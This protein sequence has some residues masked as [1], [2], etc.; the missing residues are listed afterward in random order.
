MIAR[1]P[2]LL[3][4][5][6]LAASLV[7][8]GGPGAKGRITS[9]G[10]PDA[11]KLDKVKPAAMKEFDAGLRA[12][13]LG[14]PDANATAAKRFAAAVEIDGTLWEAWHDLGVLAA[15]DG[16]D[17]DAVRA[18]GKALDVN[19][20][21]TPSRLARAEA[22]RRAGRIK[23][24]RGDY[25][26]SL[27]EFDQS[28][29]LRADAAARLASLLRDAEAYDDAVDVLRDTL[30]VAGPSSRIYTELGLIYLSQARHDLAKLVLARAIELDA[31][32]PAAYNALALLY[33][34][35]G[36]AQ[37]AFDRFDYATA[38]DPAYVDA[39]FNKAAVLLDA[40]DYQRAK[41][42]LAIIVDAS[43]DDLAARVAMGVAQRGL[44]DLPGA[45]KTWEA[46]VEDAPRRSFARADALY[47]LVILK[48]FFLED[49]AGAKAD[50]ERYMQDAP[51]SHPRRQDAE[52]KR[53]ELGL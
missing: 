49:V 36:K 30:R 8:C 25:E 50:L 9:Q 31:K 14:G 41:Q 43:D 48:A 34:A 29:P 40:G 2:M 21:H 28:D 38:L 5:A 45:K 52:E 24:A 1:V 37:E 39:R 44:K 17:D 18:F 46:V 10:R 47:D 42:E 32:N 19:P 26:G 51:T 27:R 33:L 16:D 7:G 15:A 23:E 12:L 53:K 4:A 3:V 11:P 13:R 35:E 6:L 22:H 20:A